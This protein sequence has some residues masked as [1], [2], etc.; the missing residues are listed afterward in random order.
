VNGDTQASA[1]DAAA[2]VR[3]A[4]AGDRAARD[5][6]MAAHLPTV[7]TIV[8]QVLGDDPDADDV[9]QDVMVRALRQLGSLRSPASFRPWLVAITLR[10]ISTHQDRGARAAELVPPAPFEDVTEMRVELSAQR[11]Q[12]R[13]AGRWLDASDRTVLWLW[14]LEVAG[15]LSRAELARALGVSV[16]HAGV[17]VQRVRAQLDL[18]RAVVA[19]LE[20]QP[21]CAGLAAWDG[22]PSPLWRKRLGRHVRSC[23]VCARATGDLIASDRLLPGF[24]LVPVPA[25]LGA[26]ILAKSAGAGGLVLAG[27]IAAH[28]VVATVVAGTLAVGGTV[29]VVELTEP[30]SSPAVALPAVAL[31][32]VARPAVVPTPSV[33][34]LL[35]AGPASFEAVNAAGRFV[36]ASGGLGVLTAVGPGNTVTA[37]RQATF[38]VV[39]GLTG[40]GCVAF[41]VSDGRFLRH[42]SWRV[43]ADEDDG[44][45]LFRADATFCPR[46]GE[47]AGSV[48]LEASNYPGRFLRHRGD[49]LWVDQSDGSAGFLADASFTARPPL[50]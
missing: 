36:T 11:R 48:A 12:A 39:D 45:E 30:E 3:A 17:R 20:A 15:Q 40:T 4:R 22:T 46:P 16:A 35:P 33:A 27:M 18:S 29:G 10:Q 2:L 49:D 14:W 34:G 25:G 42:A 41:R 9:V 8:R 19:A 37:R 26:A 6:L 31:P 13:R 24:V 44:T 50:G 47:A 7:Y 43:R 23:P 28:P 5:A 21:R 32:A 38:Q 1:T